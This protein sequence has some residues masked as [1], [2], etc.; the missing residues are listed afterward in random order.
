MAYCVLGL[1]R[2]WLGLCLAALVGC[3]GETGILV[4]VTRTDGVP[5]D[6]D[7]L[8]FVVG[9]AATGDTPY[10]LDEPSSV[11]NVSVAGR[12]LSTDPYRLLL[13][14][15]EKAKEAAVLVAVF[16]TKDGERVAFGGFTQAQPFM[17]GKVLLRKVVLDAEIQAVQT[18]SGCLKW[19]SGDEWVVIGSPQDQDCDD[20]DPTVGPSSQEI[21]ENGVDDNCNDMVDEITDEDG[22]QVTNCDGDCDDWD[23][24][25]NPN[26]EEI[27]DGKD[28]DCSGTCDDGF[29]E[30]GDHYTTCGTKDVGGSCE[31][32]EPDCDDTDPDIRPGAEEVCDGEDNDCSG[33]CDD[34]PELDKDMDGYTECGSRPGICGLDSELRDCAPEDPDVHPFA[35]EVCDGKD[36]DCDGKG[37]G[38]QRCYLTVTEGMATTCQEGVAQCDDDASDGN[39]G[40]GPCEQAA[41]DAPTTPALCEAYEMCVD[42][43]A[44]D[45]YACA[46]D[47]AATVLMDCT[48]TYT[49]FPGV[50]CPERR[51]PLPA[52]PQAT[53]CA[54]KILGGTSQAHYEVGLFGE[55][56][57]VP[58]PSLA[59]C[60]G[61]FGV[62]ESRRTVPQHDAV[63]LQVTSDVQLFKAVEVRITPKLV[64]SC[65]G[66]G[67]VCTTSS[68]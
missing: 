50:L 7:G 32:V 58:L 42:A 35:A 67:L 45:P 5:E 30:D 31:T 57:S 10:V 14:Q 34:D 27:C 63:Y 43:G 53:T 38:P 46:N 66:A 12:D 11:R 24:D 26:K 33:T 55:G 22:D 62:V 29:D 36:N 21:C 16:G 13:K 47:K 4:E 8:T 20:L 39:A 17:P 59:E 56:N 37:A 2:R 18:D 54:W 6:L 49:G 68:Q 15:G 19:L 52:D 51:V 61:A 48:L 25:V 44:T 65:T 1:R 41:T 3:S 9:M 28:N 23:P 60:D 40:L 64:P